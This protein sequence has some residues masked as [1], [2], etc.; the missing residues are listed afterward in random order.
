MELVQ[1]TREEGLLINVE[2]SL[3]VS[4]PARVTYDEEVDEIIQLLLH[5]G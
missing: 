3:G 4:D 2:G 5:T 1:P